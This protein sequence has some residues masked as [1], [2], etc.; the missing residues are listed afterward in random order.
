ME[1]TLE[2]LLVGTATDSFD[3]GIR[4][5]AVLEPLGG[6]GETCGCRKLGRGRWPVAMGADAESSCTA[7][8]TD[9]WSRDGAR[10]P[11]SAPTTELWAPTPVSVLVDESGLAIL[12]MVY[13]L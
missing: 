5:D 7:S 9:S 13:R 2:R 3:D 4:L 8:C 11:W 1:L 12:T 6:P 10:N